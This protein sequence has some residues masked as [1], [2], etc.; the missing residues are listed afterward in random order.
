MSEV[1][2]TTIM[3]EFGRKVAA[4]AIVAS[5]VSNRIYIGGVPQG[6]SRPYVVIWEI[7]S[8]PFQTLQGELGWSKTML[9]LDAW[10]D[11]VNAVVYA[12]RIGNAVRAIF[13]N[14]FRGQLVEGGLQVDS[15]V[16][17]RYDVVGQR[18]NDGSDDILRRC[19]MDIE[20]IHADEAGG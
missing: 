8:E 2:E 1:E 12:K 9:Q 19:S 3:H 10:A 7:I 14:G 15:V 13:A 20:I 17:T 18:K 6:V 16:V 5:V 11:G 4:D